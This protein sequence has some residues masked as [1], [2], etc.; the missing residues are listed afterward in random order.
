M[1]GHRCR[2]DSD[3]VAP[4]LPSGLTT[5]ALGELYRQRC[6]TDAL[7]AVDEPARRSVRLR[8]LD[9]LDAAEIARRLHLERD[10]A[11]TTLT[12]AHRDVVAALP[13]LTGDARCTDTRAALL[14]GTDRPD[15]IDHVRNCSACRTV[16][17]LAVQATLAD[18]DTWATPRAD[19]APAPT[20]SSVPWWRRRLV[21]GAAGVVALGLATV[22]GLV[23]VAGSGRSD[24]VATAALTGSALAPDVTATAEVFADD[25][26][27]RIVLDAPGLADPPAGRYYQAWLKRPNGLVAIGTFSRGGLVVLWSAVAPTD[28]D[29]V[30]VT[31]EPD[32]GDTTSS[33]VRVLAG[34]V[35][36]RR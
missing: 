10:R 28:G 26:G 27:F 33:G 7:A 9:G 13:W 19:P 30:T 31:V 17:L 2:C 25:A 15:D 8:H 29:A 1:P 22:A 36:V 5:A 12:V 34:T 16:D 23:T 3:R 21:A 35:T 20:T 32:D 11:I 18:P 24:P 4:A 6:L 14:A